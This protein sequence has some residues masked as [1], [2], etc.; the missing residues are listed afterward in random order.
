MPR[1]FCQL[2][3]DR[4]ASASVDRGS[5]SR[6]ETPPHQRYEEQGGYELANYAGGGYGDGSSG[7]AEG[8]YDYGHLSGGGEFHQQEASRGSGDYYEGNSAAGP[9]AYQ[10]RHY[11][12]PCDTSSQPQQQQQQQP[13]GASS[14]SLPAACPTPDPG[15][16]DPAAPLHF[17][18]IALRVPRSKSEIDLSLIHI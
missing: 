11:S 12:E 14:S 13:Y 2:L 7:G 18:G 15:T 16:S 1:I 6:W 10:H 9:D 17:A 3:P 8:G 4:Y 5:L